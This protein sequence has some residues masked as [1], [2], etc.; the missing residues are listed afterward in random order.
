MTKE[1]P[2]WERRV[3]TLL[4]VELTKRNLTYK[5]LSEKLTEIGV[6]ESEPNIRNKLARGTFSAAFF[7][8]CLAAMGAKEVKLSDG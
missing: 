1:L 8:Q 4:K 7:V 3:Q 2:E 6:S 5:Q